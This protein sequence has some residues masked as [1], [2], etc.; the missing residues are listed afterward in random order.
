MGRTS[1]CSNKCILNSLNIIYN[2]YLFNL[3]KS[4]ISPRV[5]FVPTGLRRVRVSF[6]P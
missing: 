3:H 4:Q 6:C 5:D 2:I 1:S